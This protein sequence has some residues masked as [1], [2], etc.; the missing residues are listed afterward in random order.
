MDLVETGSV[1]GDGSGA[2]FDRIATRYDLLNRL[3]SLGADR[4]WRRATAEALD[5]DR[6]GGVAR[7]LD[8]ASGT[9]DLAMA[10]ARR[11]PAATV[12]GVDSSREMTAIGRNKVARSGFGDRVELREGDALNLAFPDR[13]FDAVTIGFGIR[14][15]PDRRRALTEMAR[16]VRPG[17]AVAVLELGEPPAG[18][19]GALSRVHIRFVV[20]RVGALLAGAEEYRYL[21]RSIRAFPAVAEFARTM[22]AAGLE[23]IETR[24]LTFGVCNLF[25]GRSANGPSS[26]ETRR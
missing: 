6:A 13:S 1:S 26:A 16:V 17:G 20:P 19:A 22:A 21:E 9:G 7:V 23:S 4:R 5:L 2:M 18:V 8:V 15:I 24:S 25:L 3:N 11:Y 12:M 14:N 10:V